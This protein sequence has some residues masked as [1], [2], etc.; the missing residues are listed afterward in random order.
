MSRLRSDFLWTHND[1]GDRPRLYA[2]DLTGKHLG[3]CDV[4]GAGAVDWE[5]MASFQRD[6]TSYLLIADVGD[7][8][9]M[10][11]NLATVSGP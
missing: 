10:A 6:G 1:S 2:L 7:N 8:Q 9:R 4:E 3:T 11:K 5:D